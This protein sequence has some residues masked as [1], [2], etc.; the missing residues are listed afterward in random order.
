MLALIFRG[1][2]EVISKNYISA[3]FNVNLQVNLEPLR[4]SIY[5]FNPA[6]ENNQVF[7]VTLSPKAVMFL[8]HAIKMKV[9]LLFTFEPN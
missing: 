5:E 8:L 2:T 3:I 7:S 9:Q 1:L 6:P 4:F